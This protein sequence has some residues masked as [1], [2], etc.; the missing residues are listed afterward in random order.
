MRSTYFMAKLSR[1]RHKEDESV[2]SDDKSRLNEIFDDPLRLNEKESDDDDDDEYI[3]ENYTP[4][5]LATDRVLRVRQPKIKVEPTV[6]IKS[7]DATVSDVLNR[8]N[9]ALKLHLKRDCKRTIHF[10]VIK[11]KA[12]GC[13]ASVRR[14][15]SRLSQAV[16]VRAIVPVVDA[17]SS[18][19]LAEKR[20]YSCHLCGK[21]FQ[22]FCRLVVHMPAHSHVRRYKC[23]MCNKRYKSSSSLN[24]HRNIAHFGIPRKSRSNVKSIKSEPI[25]R[26]TSEQA[27]G[28]TPNIEHENEQVEMLTI[29]EEPNDETDVEMAMSLNIQE[30]VIQ[31]RKP[32]IWDACETM[33]VDNP[34][35]LDSVKQ[36]PIDEIDQNTE[37]QESFE[38]SPMMNHPPK[39]QIWQKDTADPWAYYVDI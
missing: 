21:H 38:A 2:N 14:R 24:V 30:L 32:L 17:I 28:E 18:D 6:E 3:G 11:P 39:N 4:V 5:S 35:K 26:M 7:N 34:L 37:T 12:N 25:E 36:E 31:N 1:N 19:D 9:D 15:S 16:P 20:T 27:V 29:K 22:H 23:T 8:E 33:H 13:A 10:K